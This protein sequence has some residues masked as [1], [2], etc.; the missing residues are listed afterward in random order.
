MTNQ[1]AIVRAA[2]AAYYAAVRAGDVDAIAPIFAP[3]AVMRDPVGM[4]PAT[5]DASRRQ[6]YA[7]IA[8][9]FE[10]FGIFE[11]QVAVCGYEAAA[12]WTARGATKDGKQVSFE[13]ISTFVFDD[14]GKI[15]SMSA[16][17][18]IATVMA[19]MQG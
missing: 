13:G 6:R 5:D 16:Y 10:T 3:T 14:D 4:P 18:E 2:V 1:D 12:R 11:D 19:A 15:V 8:A 7:G 9:T 17:F